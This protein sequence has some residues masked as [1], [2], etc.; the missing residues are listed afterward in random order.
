MDVRKPEQMIELA[1]LFHKMVVFDPLIYHLDEQK[2]LFWQALDSRLE[3]NKLQEER[4]K[5]EFFGRRA[6]DCIQSD[7]DDLAMVAFISKKVLRMGYYEIADYDD[8]LRE[9]ALI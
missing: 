6:F 8:D 2:L 5:R 3:P 4:S 7:S 1:N 9:E